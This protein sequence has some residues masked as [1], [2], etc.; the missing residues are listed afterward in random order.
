MNVKVERREQ[1]ADDDDDLSEM[2]KNIL[3]NCRLVLVVF[4]VTFMCTMEP[5]YMCEED[6]GW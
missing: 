2:N 6:G 3:L 5:Y 1:N 4:V